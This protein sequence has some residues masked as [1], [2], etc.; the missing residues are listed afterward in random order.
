[1]SR[2]RRDAG[3]SGGWRDRVR[4]FFLFTFALVSF[5]L[6]HDVY[7]WYAFGGERTQLRVLAPMIDAA[8]L[9]VVKTQLESD[10]LR[11]RIEAM[12]RALEA[13]RGEF[14]AYDERAAGGHLTQAL[15]QEYRAR[16]AS[17]NRRVAARNSWFVKWQR[18]VGH[19]RDAVRRYNQ[20]ADESRS[21]A[22]AMGEL[23]YNVPS[24]VEAAVRNGL[25]P[26]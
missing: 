2:A 26:E 3:P 20:L 25:R 9:Q 18:A 7:R 12:D 8:G 24:P 14:S 16:V 23:H 21:I 10:G 13:S 5:E 15:Y 1:V 22:A 17:Y 4:V 19:N 11:T 6:A